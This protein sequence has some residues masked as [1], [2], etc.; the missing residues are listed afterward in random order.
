MLMLGA[1]P[2]ACAT[3]HASYPSWEPTPLSV[4]AVRDRRV[5]LADL[6][7]SRGLWLQRGWASYSYVRTRQTDPDEVEFT[8]VVVDGD[9]VVQRALLTSAANQT[10]LGDR[11]AGKVGEVP[12]LLW[13]ERGK[14][15][16]RNPGGAPA[17]TLA[18]LYDLCRDRVLSARSE[19][20]PR[21]SFHRDGLL[22]HCGFLREDCPDCT[23]V[24]VQ[25]V[26]MATPRPWQAPRDVLCTDRYGAFIMDQ[27]PLTGFPC[28]LCRCEGSNLSDPNPPPPPPPGPTLSPE[29]LELC[30]LN[31]GD[32][33][34]P[35]SG[36]TDICKIDPAACPPGDR[37]PNRP[38]W[39]SMYLLSADCGGGPVW[40]LTPECLAMPRPTSWSD[41]DRRARCRSG[42]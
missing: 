19:H 6:E 5:A 39:V 1:S 7:V 24:S 25:T 12:Q 20:A 29:A 17:L 10:A 4:P 35:R 15:V 3:L 38:N 32:C 22:Q 8:L 13:R 41:S 16:G 30:R 14:E 42:R 28:E 11:L 36:E 21:L 2:M 18:E 26:G 37:L 31:G 9:Q 33:V 34:E 27:E 23:V 40:A